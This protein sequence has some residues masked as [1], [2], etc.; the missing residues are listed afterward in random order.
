MTLALTF[1]ALGLAFPYIVLGIF[2]ALV[3]LLPQPGEWMES[4]KQGLSF[5]LFA[6]AAWMLDVYL[7]FLPEEYSADQMWIL[8]SLVVFC[9][10]FWVYGRWCPIYQ[11]KKTRWIGG[12]I[13]VLLVAVGVWGSKPRPVSDTPAPATAT[14]AATAGY[15]V[16]TGEHP[17][18]NTWSKALMDKALAEGHPVYVDF[19]AKWCATCQMNK[20]T[21]Y[22]ADVCAL[23]EQGKVVLMRADKTRPVAEIDAE[24]R[25]LN[26][27]SVPVNVLYMPGKE[28][29]ITTELLTPI[30]M[31][32]FLTEKLGLK[33]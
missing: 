1:M 27:S 21:A 18:W 4:L 6:A 23:F 29:A 13:A 32:G 2:P 17:T 22:T 11:S 7:A 19:T 12:I 16:A 25:S 33:K 24:M 26:R 8:M 9:S 15:V 30:Y 28:P 31:D 20:K 3:R 14:D 5:L 10:A